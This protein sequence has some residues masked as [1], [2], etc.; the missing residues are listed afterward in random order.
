MLSQTMEKPMARKRVEDKSKRDDVAVK[1][2]RE[3]TDK[4]KLVASR[5]RITLAEYMTELSRPTI[6]RDFAK[7]IREMKGD[8]E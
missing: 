8:G 4:A 1:L 7:V 6:E 3:L 5:K 2:D